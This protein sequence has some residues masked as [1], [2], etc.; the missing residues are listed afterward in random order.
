MS[1]K[2]GFAVR[3]EKSQNDKSAEG[4]LTRML[5][6]VTQEVPK[7]GGMN[8][9]TKTILAKVAEA[10]EEMK[11]TEDKRASLSRA[12]QILKEYSSTLEEYLGNIIAR[13][14]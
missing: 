4:K 11:N 5:G 1:R 14:T 7:D 2:V 12:S 13:N 10:D 9:A 3:I 6:K 8:Q